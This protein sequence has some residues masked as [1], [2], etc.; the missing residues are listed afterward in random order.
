MQIVQGREQVARAPALGERDNNG[1]LIRIS[2]RLTF[3]RSKR[4]R[5]VPAASQR[6]RAD[7]RGIKRAAAPNENNL[8]FER[9]REGRG[10]PRFGH[11]LPDVGLVADLSLEL[12]AERQ[13][14]WI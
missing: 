12:R 14:L 8:P 4:M 1:S 6:E 9:L 10:G 5:V 11:A 2:I 7:L 13:L 3:G